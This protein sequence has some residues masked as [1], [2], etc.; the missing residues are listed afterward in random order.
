M[1]LYAHGA[2]TFVHMYLC[3]RRLKD[4]VTCLALSIF[5]LSLWCR[6]SRNLESGWQSTSP[7]EPPVFASHHA[8]SIGIRDCAQ[9]FSV[10]SGHLN[11]GSHAYVTVPLLPCYRIW[12]L[13][14]ELLFF[15]EFMSVTFLSYPADTISESYFQFLGSHSLSAPSFTIFPEP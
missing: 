11:T 10:G 1:S 5:P 3:A 7:T 12:S 15:W 9:L 14:Q 6:I 4:N 8:G 2:R 13:L